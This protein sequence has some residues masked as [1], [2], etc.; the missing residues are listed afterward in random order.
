[1]RPDSTNPLSPPPNPNT[2]RVLIVEDEPDIARLIAVTL[3]PMRL[4]LRLASTGPQALAAFEQV[5]PH[6]VI[7]DVML[8]EMDGRQVCAKIRET[9]TVPIIMM[10]AMDSETAQLE[11]LKAGADDY[12]A[13]PFNPKVLAARVATHLRRVYRYDSQPTRETTEDEKR[14]SARQS[15]IDSVVGHSTVERPERKLPPGWAGCD[16]CGYMGPRPKF[17]KENALG[18]KIAACPVCANTES[19][20]FSLG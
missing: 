6:L 9:S 14:I 16:V 7:L 4:D 17:D 11:G 12:I 15:V 8:P 3:T 18:R 19:I 5:Q 2:L 13:K 1:M 20:V 10:T